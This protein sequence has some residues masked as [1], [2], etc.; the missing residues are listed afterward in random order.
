MTRRL[1]VGEAAPTRMKD[2]QEEYLHMAPAL[3]LPRVVDTVPWSPLERRQNKTITS[4]KSKYQRGH[5]ENNQ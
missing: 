1:S 3:A 2:T 5:Y 4:N